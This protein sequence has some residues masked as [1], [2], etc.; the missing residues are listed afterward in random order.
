M[1]GINDIEVPKRTAF[2]PYFSRS[3]RYHPFTGMP[4][5]D[6]Y[7]D[8]ISARLTE[9]NYPVLVEHGPED[10]MWL[11]QVRGLDVFN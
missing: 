2:L 4:I 6:S 7:D 11:I 5:S 10:Q 1:R 3:V 9:I 8:G